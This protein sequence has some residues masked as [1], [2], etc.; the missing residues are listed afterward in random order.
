MDDPT[1]TDHAGAPRRY[2][3]RLE[4][5]LDDHW[6]ASFEGFTL[7]RDARETRLTGTVVDQAAL[8]GLLRKVR[9]LG[10]VLIALDPLDD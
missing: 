4:G 8:H 6:A 3:I 1:P 2:E 9:D 5:Y 7:R 10:L